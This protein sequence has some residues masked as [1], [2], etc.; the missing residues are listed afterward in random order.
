LPD[1]RDRA[2]AQECTYGV[3]RWFH[4]LDHQLQQLLR[5]PLRERDVDIHMLLL[6]GLYQ[7]QYLQIAAHAA[8]SATV[9][10]CQ[11]LGKPWAKSLLNAILRK[12]LREREQL[13]GL[14]NQDEPARWAHPQWLIDEI[15]ADWP[16]QWENVLTEN[17]RRG[18]LCLRI[19]RRKIA[20]GAYLDLL[21][22]AGLEALPTRHAE[23]GVR[24]LEPVPVD[25]LPGFADGYASVQDEA[26]QLAAGLLDVPDN[27]HVLDACAAPGGKTAHILEISP[28]NVTVTAL[29]SDRARLDDLEANLGRLGLECRTI[30]SPAA[31]TERWWNGSS[32]DRIL[33]DAPCSATGVI[34]R[35][36]DIK[37][38]RRQTDLE[39]LENQQMALLD[40]VW[41]LLRG[42]GMLVY[43]TCTILTRENDDVIDAFLGRVNGAESRS[44]EAAWGQPSRYGRQILPGVEQMDGFY[45]ACIAKRTRT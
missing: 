45:Y 11:T 41:P 43:A 33:L 38:L 10:A 20:R 2:L 23:D 17:N 24:L 22:Q 6:V 27:G 39:Q 30:C 42:G 28:P 31:D 16:A 18:P 7:I 1:R 35:H 4:R 15:R 32:Y 34:R 26:A 37:F 5:R 8:V 25:D 12:A 3:L 44:I 9:D 29:D 36:P 40:T 14:A 21:E 13:E 19:N